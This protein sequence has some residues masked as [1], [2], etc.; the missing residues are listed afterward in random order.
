MK[1]VELQNS[2][3]LDRLTVVDR[4]DPQPAAGQVLLKL[5]A[6]SLNYRDLMI[7]QG[8][9]APQQP[10]PLIPL[11]DGV[12]EVVAIG[13]G[14]SRVKVGD[15]VASL[16]FQKW[17]SGRPTKTALRSTLGSPT[18]G[19]LSEL[20]VLP[21]DGVISVPAHLSDEAAATLPC[22]AVTAWNALISGGGLKA[23]DTVLLQGTGGVSLFALQFAT[24]TGA[25][26]IILSSS[27]EKL[28][29]SRRMGAAHGINYKTTPD[30]EEEVYRL[31][32]GEGVDHVVEVGG[33]GTLAK[34]LRSTKMGGRVSSIGVLTGTELNTSLLA[35]VTRSIRLQGIYVGSREMFE[36]MNRAIALHKLQPVVDRVF[37]F[38]EAREALQYLE[39]GA[40]FGK[41]CLRFDE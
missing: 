33:A 30:W 32:N 21:E 10:L 12:G 40:H 15:R 24:L 6:A 19:V 23:G 41:I 31:T 39:S 8:S 7:V 5:K 3:G 38:R 29:R 26:V 13:A 16:F 17:L 14:V 2:F 37:S 28:E 34:S 27:D 11:S 36:A 4:P 25:Q 20:I 1:A 9:Y 18:D 22:A 35:I